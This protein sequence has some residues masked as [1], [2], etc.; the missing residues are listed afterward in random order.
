MD[1]WTLLRQYADRGSQ[2]AFAELVNR[3]IGMVYAVCR[4]RLHNGHDAEDATQAVFI[5]LAAK[6]RRLRR[7]TVL[8]GWLYRT[9]DFVAAKAHRR[10]VNRSKHESRAAAA[11]KTSETGS[12]A[13]DLSRSA[14]LDTALKRLSEAERHAVVLRFLEDR[15]LR[16][17]ASELRVTEEAA[18]K[19]VGRAVERLR[20]MMKHAGG[21]VWSTVAVCDVLLRSKCGVPLG[22]ADASIRAAAAG[23]SSAAAGAV[24]AKGAMFMMAMSRLKTASLCL[25]VAGFLL[26][27]AAI[28]HHALAAGPE[29]PTP[30]GVVIDMDGNSV[31]G[32]PVELA[33][34]DHR[35]GIYE[36]PAAPDP[37]RSIRTDARGRFSFPKPAG[38]YWVVVKDDRGY[39]QASAE[40]LGA[41]HE[42]V[43]RAWAR[44]S[45]Q[46]KFGRN[47]APGKTVTLMGLI[48]WPSEGDYPIHD[49]STVT[50]GVDGRFAFSRV[51][52]GEFQVTRV[53]SD[54]GFQMAP[55]H[56]VLV[57]IPPGKAIEVNV[58]GS[59]RAVVGRVV[60]PAGAKVPIVWDPKGYTYGEVYR[61]A[62]PFIIQPQLTKAQ[63][64][65]ALNQFL[66]TPEGKQ[67][68][69]AFTQV[70]RLVLSPDG[71]FRVD[72][73]P[74]GRY[75]VKVSNNSPDPR[76]GRPTYLGSAGQEFTIEAMPLGW[77]DEPLNLGDL[78]LKE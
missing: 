10:S 65:E 36:S 59:G 60:P 42:V 75:G 5:I 34:S 19:R 78:M 30:D 63:Q 52:P 40:E 64:D 71:S 39:G 41:R 8:A 35:V 29:M 21:G 68:R 44:V 32:A 3:H 11:A 45:G 16:D 57:D 31:A 13:A 15:P 9:A 12:V 53:P 61:V 51:A 76:T 7:G 22:L 66:R 73:L 28:V 25:I 1:D 56:P 2:A 4:R 50:A 55:L 67:Y 49:S 47:P 69:R 43:I 70:Y 17:V 18:R 6:A 20:E 72:D 62:K 33:T 46:V 54:L 26:G 23:T 14:A 37:A 27:T 48:R 74:A 38:H 77:N 24:I 58:G